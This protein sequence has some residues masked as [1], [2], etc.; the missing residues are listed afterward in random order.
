M[1]APLE[2]FGMVSHD[3]MPRLEQSCDPQIRSISTSNE[4]SH[5]E[6]LALGLENTEPTAVHAWLMRRS[7][8]NCRS[9]GTRPPSLA[10]RT[11][12]SILRIGT[13]LFE[14]AYMQ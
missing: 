14:G 5:T 12:G 3:R 1:A 6:K 11:I 2:V 13:S 4:S 7:K 9:G 8:P 10:H